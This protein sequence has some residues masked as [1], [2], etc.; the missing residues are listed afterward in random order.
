MTKSRGR[1]MAVAS[2]RSRRAHS[3]WNVDIQDPTPTHCQQRLHASTQFFRCLVREGDGKN[4]IR[5]R[6]AFGDQVRNPLR[7]HARLARAGAGQDEQRAVD[8]QNGVALFRIEC[9]ELIHGKAWLRTPGSGRERGVHADRP[10]F[11]GAR[12]KPILP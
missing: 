9:C 6:E 5:L 2:R 1:P 8:V 4:F 11:P 3:E 10:K 12:V 7:D